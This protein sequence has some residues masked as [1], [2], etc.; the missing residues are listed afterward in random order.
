MNITPEDVNGAVNGITNVCV[1][2]VCSTMFPLF[3]NVAAVAGVFYVADVVTKYDR[4][5]YHG[6]FSF[7]DVEQSRFMFNSTPVFRFYV[8]GFFTLL[9]SNCML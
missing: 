3:E 7:A 4:A 8:V 1:R 6:H 5:V 9:I 2:P